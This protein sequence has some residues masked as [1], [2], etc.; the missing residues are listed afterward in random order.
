MF[1]NMML[2]IV[3]MFMG[4][5]RRLVSM[6]KFTVAMGHFLMGMLMLMLLF[7]APS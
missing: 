6:F 2:V 1:M 4:V 5:H 3:D 7:F